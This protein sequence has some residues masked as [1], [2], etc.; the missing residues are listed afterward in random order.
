MSS[1]ISISKDAY[2]WLISLEAIKIAFPAKEVFDD[3]VEI[4]GAS[5]YFLSG[6]VFNR[7]FEGLARTLPKNSTFHPD[8][9]PTSATKHIYNPT[10][11]AH[12]WNNIFDTMKKFGIPFDPEIKNL[13]MNG[14][15]DVLAGTLDDVFKFYHP[16]GFNRF[17]AI[18]FAKKV[19][20]SY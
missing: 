19:K 17:Q 4:E 10:E 9:L 5:D 3:K 2:D 7:L 20:I 13:I 8:K 16:K 14:D 6:L 15:V 18:E 1:K 11:R 12:N